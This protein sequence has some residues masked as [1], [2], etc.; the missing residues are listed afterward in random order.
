METQQSQT[1]EDPK[2]KEEGENLKSYTTENKLFFCVVSVASVS[3]YSK[4][5]FFFFAYVKK[6]L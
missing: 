5:F 2:T 4:G 6:I 3:A 1:M